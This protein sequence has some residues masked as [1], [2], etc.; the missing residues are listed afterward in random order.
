MTTAKLSAA[1]NTPNS[2]QNKSMETYPHIELP[3]FDHLVTL[4][5]EDPDAFEALREKLCGQVIERAPERSKKRLEGIQFTVDM[6]RQR[7]RTNVQAC[8]R[9]S[10]MMQTALVELNK[11]L[12]KAYDTPQQTDEST[13]DIIPLFK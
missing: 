13:A 11:T 2:A 8:L 4:A 10:E 6:E 5:N 1:N 12:N 7:C 3:D 9:I